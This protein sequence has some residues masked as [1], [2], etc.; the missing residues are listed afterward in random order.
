MLSD[1]FTISEVLIVREKAKIKVNPF[2]LVIAHTWPLHQWSSDGF[3]IATTISLGVT[4]CNPNGIGF[5]TVASTHCLI[6]LYKLRDEMKLHVKS[7]VFSR[8]QSCD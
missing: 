2:S 6:L 1:I 3:Y 7:R 5:R 8:V 4:Q